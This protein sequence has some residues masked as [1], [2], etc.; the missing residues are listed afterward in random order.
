MFL[1][2]VGE[3]VTTLRSCDVDDHLA[4]QDDMHSC[5]E[6]HGDWRRLYEA[7]ERPLDEKYWSGIGATHKP[8]LGM[9]KLTTQWFNVCRNHKRMKWAS[10]GPQDKR[11]GC[12]V[13]KSQRK[14]YYIGEVWR[15]KW[16]VS[17]WL[18]AFEEQRS[19]EVA[20]LTKARR[21]WTI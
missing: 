21:R 5:L 3:L 1:I 6:V 10:E 4:H 7:T 16:K 12:N 13:N 19:I 18:N 9:T 20:V 11:W 14:A 8:S 2:C 15:I 17:H